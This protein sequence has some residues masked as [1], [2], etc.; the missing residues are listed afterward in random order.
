MS[1]TTCTSSHYYQDILLDIID[2]KSFLKFL[3]A[4]QLQSYDMKQKQILRLGSKLYSDE[5]AKISDSDRLLVDDLFF[6]HK[7][8]DLEQ[9][10]GKS[11]AVDIKAVR[12]DW[13][14]DNSN[15][16]G[17]WF[18]QAIEDNDDRLEIFGN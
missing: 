8:G 12:I 16:N 13:I 7:L 14:L 5:I 2:N 15:E 1:V 17:Y 10:E 11:V 6:K 3:D 18:L 4:S 9:G